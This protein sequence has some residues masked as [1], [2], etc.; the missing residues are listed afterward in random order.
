MARQLVKG[1][2]PHELDARAAVN[3]V[4]RDFLKSNLK[5]ALSALVAV[6]VRVADQLIV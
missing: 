4:S 1:V 5:H 6:M 3:F 2:Q